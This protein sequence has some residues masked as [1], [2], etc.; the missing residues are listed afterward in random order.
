MMINA[1]RLRKLRM[2][3]DVDKRSY[4]GLKR[5]KI[6]GRD[7][8]QLPLELFSIT[9]LEVLDL[10]PERESSLAFS[11][12]RVPSAI[13][14]LVNLRVLMLDT[15][16][17]TELPVELGTL[18]NLER[19]SLSNNHLS[20]LPP[21]FD[22]LRNM[23]SLHAANNAFSE[24]PTSICQL[25]ELE[26][27]DLSDNKLVAIPDDVSNLT[28]LQTFLLFMNNLSAVPDSICRLV[29]LRVLWLGS[30]NLVEL[31]REFG[32]LKSLDWGHSHTSSAAIDGNPLR[33][34]PVEVC[35][36]GIDAITSYFAQART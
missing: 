36:H 12:M 9:E 27:L 4:P 16:E 1:T 6:R 21:G 13:G 22:R 20:C 8:M 3:I 31:P 11:V 18:S 19:M 7:L 25:T 2:E 30:N 14:R 29:G 28:N 10:S 32:R 24:F 5:L 35:R 17:L 23:R 33:R 15:N 34:P 26:F